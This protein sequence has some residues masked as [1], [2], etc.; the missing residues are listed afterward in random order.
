MQQSKH[1]AYTVS[2]CVS[3]TFIRENSD[4]VGMHDIVNTSASELIHIH[5]WHSAEDWHKGP[6]E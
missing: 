5:T 2:G 6:S 4:L 3:R 1:A